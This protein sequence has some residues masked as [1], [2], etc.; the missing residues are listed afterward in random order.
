MA[1]VVIRRRWLR[2]RRPITSLGRWVRALPCSSRGQGQNQHRHAELWDSS[3]FHLQQHCL[4]Q[5]WCHTSAPP[6]DVVGLS[7]LDIF[8]RLVWRLTVQSHDINQA[9]WGRRQIWASRRNQPDESV[10]PATNSPTSAK[11]RQI[12]AT[13]DVG[14]LRDTPLPPAYCKILILKDLRSRTPAKY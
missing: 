4:P 11:R 7:A 3:A 10:R 1:E 5:W 9:G 12:R 14:H 6:V 2:C 13:G 8:R